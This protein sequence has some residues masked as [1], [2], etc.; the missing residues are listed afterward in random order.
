MMAGC[1]DLREHVE[2]LRALSFKVGAY[3]PPSEGGSASLLLRVTEN[4]P[5]N[6]CTSTSGS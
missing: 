6:R 2:R 5:W 4:Y 1:K 3:R